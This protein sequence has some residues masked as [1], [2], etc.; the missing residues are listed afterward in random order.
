MFNQ[1]INRSQLGYAFYKIQNAENY[2]YYPMGHS[3][4]I[5]IKTPEFTRPLQ[6][7]LHWPQRFWEPTKLQIFYRKGPVTQ[8]LTRTEAEK[9]AK[10]YYPSDEQL[11]EVITKRIEHHFGFDNRVFIKDDIAHARQVKDSDMQFIG[12]ERSW[13]CE[14]EY[15][16]NIY[17][18]IT[19]EIQC[20]V[21]RKALDEDLGVYLKSVDKLLESYTYLMFIENRLNQYLF[22]DVFDS[23]LFDK[24][25]DIQIE[26]IVRK[27]I[28]FSYNH[29]KSRISLVLKYTKRPDVCD[30]ITNKLM[31]KAI[32]LDNALKVAR[33]ET[34]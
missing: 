30:L 21:V 24:S 3:S 9:Y 33:L 19:S 2:H 29:F 23:E 28:T 27:N 15:M 12:V 34:A 7:K 25:I 14:S 4:D 8:Y 6:A 16:C 18:N 10:K 26:R 17:Q 32:E 31:P 5:E 1:K 13:F 22:Y 11:L 20:S